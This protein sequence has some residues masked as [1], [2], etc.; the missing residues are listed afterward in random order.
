MLP[1]VGSAVKVT[2]TPAQ[3]GFWEALTDKLTGSSG[4]T[5]IEIAPEVAGL[6]I[7][8]VALEVGGAVCRATL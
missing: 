4:F 5:V 8:Q 7:A 1:F 2:E 3:T 6:S